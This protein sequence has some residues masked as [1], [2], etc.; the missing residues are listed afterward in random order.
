MCHTSWDRVLGSCDSCGVCDGDCVGHTPSQHLKHTLTCASGC[1]DIYWGEWISDPPDK[2]DPCDNCGN[3]VGPQ[4]CPP[5]FF[6]CLAAG[7]HSIWGFRHGGACCGVMGGSYDAGW[8]VMKGGEP[9]IEAPVITGAPLDEELQ[10]EL[11]PP[12]S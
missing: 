5:G 1:G 10:Q 6:H 2:C 3:F 8:D 7:W 12:A 9:I 11:S 4:P